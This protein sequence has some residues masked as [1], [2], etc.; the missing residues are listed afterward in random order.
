MKN[1]YFMFAEFRKPEFIKLCKKV[2]QVSRH[3]YPLYKILKAD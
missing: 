2:Q 1:I 3:S